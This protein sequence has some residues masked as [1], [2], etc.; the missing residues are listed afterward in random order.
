MEN[1]LI[2]VFLGLLG[3]VMGSF[4]GALVW[5]LH[6]RK[7]FVNDRSE[8]ERCHHKLSILDLVPL[9]SFIFLRGRCRYCRKKIDR[10][11]FAIEIISAAVF[12]LSYLFF[13]L[14]EY[15]ELLL[16]LWLV[17][18]T[19]FLTLGLY[20]FKYKLLPNKV[21]YPTFIAAAVFFVVKSVVASQ[22]LL[23]TLSEFALALL[24]V[25]GFYLSLWLIGEVTKKS[26]I[27]LGDVKL[28][29]ILAC[30]L[31]W[32]GAVSTLFL[33]NIIGAIVMLPMLV[34]KKIKAKQT[35]P[36]GPFLLIA[37][38]VVFLCQI[39]IEKIISLMYNI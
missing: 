4:A 34:S 32:G 7:N 38:V 6:G 14:A 11:T 16:T 23:G 15:K 9:F 39:P 1:V 29:V 2:C 17:I 3:A 20:D 19:G 12:V 5:R 37:A 8:C 35:V 27:G 21:V 33:A 10:S 28:G 31:T 13:P 22:G 36:F 25:G 24:P 26:L 30:F 18:M